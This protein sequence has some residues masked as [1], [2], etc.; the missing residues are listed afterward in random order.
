MLRVDGQLHKPMGDPPPD[1]DA[2]WSCALRS[3][4]YVIDP[5]AE[6]YGT[7]E[8]RL[9]ACWHAVGRRTPKTFA[10]LGGV[11]RLGAKRNPFR[12]TV[13]EAVLSLVKRR[14]EQV[15]ILRKQLERAELE[16]LMGRAALADLQKEPK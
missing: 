13:E 3:Y 16:L 9:E 7:T 14:E 6:I 2:V 4:S 8:P 11:Y 15:R 1:V 12:P 10:I 5:D